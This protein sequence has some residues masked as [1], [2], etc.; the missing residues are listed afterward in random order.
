MNKFPQR[1]WPAAAPTV[2]D[3]FAGLLEPLGRRQRLSVIQFLFDAF[4]DAGSSRT[5]EDVVALPAVHP[6]GVRKVEIQAAH[7]TDRRGGGS[8][9]RRGARTPA[10]PRSGSGRLALASPTTAEWRTSAV[11]RREGQR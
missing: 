8:N 11:F 5:R 2:A 4:Y 9:G 3:E 10:S 1:N 7:L 6:A